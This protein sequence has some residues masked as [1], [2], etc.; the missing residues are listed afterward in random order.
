MQFH[1]GP[2]RHAALIALLAAMLASG[3]G[4]AQTSPKFTLTVTPLGVAAGEKMIPVEATAGVNVTLKNESGGALSKVTLTA[5]LNGVKFVPEGDWKADGDNA[6]LEIASVNPNEEVTKRLTLRVEMAPMPPGKRAEII[7]EAKLGDVSTS[8]SVKFPVGDCAAA[9][10]AE[11]TRLRI[12]TISEV[13]P[14]ADEM[15]KPDTKLPRMRQFRIGMRKNNDLATIDR[16][17]AGYQA[18]LL[19]HYDFFSEG[20]RYTAR[21]WADELKAFAG[22]ETNPGICAVNEGMLQG[23]RKTINYVTVRLEPQIKAHARAMESLRKHFDAEPGD[24][25]KKIALRV[26]EAAGVKF[27]SEPATTLELIV[28]AKDS[29]KDVKLTD[30]QLDN[31]SLLESAAWVEAQAMRSK[32]LNDLI[33]GSIN[34][35]GEAQKKS[36]VCAY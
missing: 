26:A 31:L 36:C 8:A 30:E 29:L 1:K 24:D 23:I 28:R 33:E 3:P 9:F 27:E 14:M 13:W 15:R 7:I 20:V 21:R 35:I 2:R 22:Q 4:D 19:A 10:Q 6:V 5:K 25:L 16:L 34:G 11:L 32:K 17:A 12:D 18:R